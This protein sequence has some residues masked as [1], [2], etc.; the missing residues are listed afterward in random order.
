MGGK[1]FNQKPV[2][3]ATDQVTDSVLSWEI[4]FAFE[5]HGPLEVGPT[6]I[7]EKP[8]NQHVPGTSFP[9]AKSTRTTKNQITRT[10]ELTC[11]YVPTQ[12]KT[13]HGS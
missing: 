6:K 13:P 4:F 12:W 5:S 9:S 10:S 8:T 11:L 2:N 3:S 1:T 7:P